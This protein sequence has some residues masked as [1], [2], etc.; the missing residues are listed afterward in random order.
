MDSVLDMYT[1]LGGLCHKAICSQEAVL[2][3]YEGQ[4]LGW[5]GPLSL[6]SDWSHWRPWAPWPKGSPLSLSYLW[7]R[8][9]GHTPS[10]SWG[11]GVLDLALQAAR[12]FPTGAVWKAERCWVPLR[13]GLWSSTAISG[14][15]PSSAGWG[16]APKGQR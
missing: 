16:E 14:S 1:C 6:C 2:L 3:W 9:Q 12:G 10:M 13:D 7:V 11:T 5:E 4:W 8:A 15:W